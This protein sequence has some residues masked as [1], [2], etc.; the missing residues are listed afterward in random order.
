MKKNNESSDTD[1]DCTNVCQKKLGEGREQ[2][3]T[4]QGRGGEERRT[5]PVSFGK[6]IFARFHSLLY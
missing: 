5:K 2:D 6:N 3:K 1:Y 4:A